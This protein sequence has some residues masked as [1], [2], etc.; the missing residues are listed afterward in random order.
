[1]AMGVRGELFELIEIIL[2]MDGLA[3][4]RITKQEN[5]FKSFPV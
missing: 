2:R 5:L 1:M 3:I 4:Y